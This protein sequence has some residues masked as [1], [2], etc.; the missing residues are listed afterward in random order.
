M[1]GGG[2]DFFHPKFTLKTGY[3]GGVHLPFLI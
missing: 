3:E 2:G 1:E